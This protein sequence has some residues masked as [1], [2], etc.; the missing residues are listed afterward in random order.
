M[1]RALADMPAH[2]AEEALERYGRSVDDGVRSRQGFMVGGRAERCVRGVG[3]VCACGSVMGGR[4]G[5]WAGGAA[6]GLMR[7]QRWGP[8]ALLFG[9]SQRR[10]VMSV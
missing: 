9:E 4:L 6:R 1:V 3:S 7:R 5:R 8:S 2:L 10:L